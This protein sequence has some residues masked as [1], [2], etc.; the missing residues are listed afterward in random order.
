MKVEDVCV[1]E[2]LRRE[3]IS[4]T[5]GD[6]VYE[7]RRGIAS[8]ASVSNCVVQ[9]LAAMGG[10]VGMGRSEGGDAGSG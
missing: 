3:R 4:T 10:A 6:V 9:Q 2:V 7:D 8:S 1:S 5:S